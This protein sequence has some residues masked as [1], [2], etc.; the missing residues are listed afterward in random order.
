MTDD[1]CIEVISFHGF[2]CFFDD[3]PADSACD[4]GGDGRDWEGVCALYAVT[5]LADTG[6]L[7]ACDD[8][9]AAIVGPSSPTPHCAWAFCITLLLSSRNMSES[10]SR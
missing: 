4:A 8:D 3:E 5:E 2:C 6:D 7:D 9:S 10:W 1:A